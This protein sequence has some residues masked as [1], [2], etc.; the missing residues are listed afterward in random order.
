MSI[1]NIG[2][3]TLAT[4]LSVFKCPSSQLLGGLHG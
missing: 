1:D 3:W 4:A 2:V